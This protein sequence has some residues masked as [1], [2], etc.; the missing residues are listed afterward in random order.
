MLNESKTVANESSA[1]LDFYGDYLEELG[2][3]RRFYSG[4]R[5]FSRDN[6]TVGVPRST[7]K[8]S[9]S[10]K[11]KS[12]S[13]MELNDVGKDICAY[14]SLLII[15]RS[16]STST[17]ALGVVLKDEFGKKDGSQMAE[18]IVRLIRLCSNSEMCE[19][20][21]Q[22][23]DANPHA[24]H[25]SDQ[26]FS[27]GSTKLFDLLLSQLLAF[28]RT[29]GTSAS[30]LKQ[31]FLLLLR[32]EIIRLTGRSISDQV[33][34]DQEDCIPHLLSERKRESR[35]SP[36]IKFV[37]WI[38]R[39]IVL[40]WRSDPPYRDSNAIMM[41]VFQAW[42]FG[43]RSPSTVF[44]SLAARVLSVLVQ[45]VWS[46][47]P[48]PISDFKSLVDYP[49]IYR[50]TL[51]MLS[52][53]R[54]LA[55]TCS[56]YFINIADL[57]MSLTT[58]E[59]ATS[60]LIEESRTHDGVFESSM[61]NRLYSDDSLDFWSGRITQNPTAAFIDMIDSI[62]DPPLLAEGCLVCRSN[63]TSN[64]F[65]NGNFVGKFVASADANV[66]LGRV[67]DY[68]K[69]GESTSDSTRVVR[70]DSGAVE[71]VRWN[72]AD[73]EFDVRHVEVDELG[74]L[75]RIFP[76][77][78]STLDKEKIRILKSNYTHGVI[79]R[80]NPD[81]FTGDTAESSG[82]MEWPE[83]G[84]C[85]LV[86]ICRIGS[87][88]YSITE[89]FFLSGMQCSHGWLSRFASRTWEPGTTYFVSVDQGS[90]DTH[91]INLIG[92]YSLIVKVGSYDVEISGD[93]AFQQSRL[94]WFDARLKSPALSI[95]KDNFVVTN[96][97][98][99]KAVC[100][101]HVGFSSGVH[102]WEF[103]IEQADSGFAFLGVA[104]RPLDLEPSNLNKWFG[105]GMVS[106]RTAFNLLHK[107]SGSIVYGEHFHTGDVVG[108]HLDMN[109]GRLAFFLDGM[110]YGEHLL[111]AMGE[112]FDDL[113]GSDR[114][115]TL[116]LYPIVGLQ[117]IQDRVALTSKWISI[118]GTSC[119]DD[120]TCIY[121]TWTLI[122][123]CYVSSTFARPSNN[124]WLYSQ[125]CR[126]FIAW[127]RGKSRNVRSRA[128]DIQTWLLLDL[129][130]KASAE[131]SI[132][133]GLERALFPG[134]RIKI[135]KSCGR[136]LESSEEAIILGTYR[137]RLWYRLT[138]DNVSEGS[139]LAWCLAPYDSEGLSVLQRGGL[140]PDRL[141]NLELP[142]I[143]Q[144]RGGALKVTCKDGAVMRDGLEI[145]TAD[146]I[147]TIE[148]QTIVFAIEKRLNSSNIV[149]YRV[150]HN[151][152]LGW[153][154]AFMR[155]GT[156]DIMVESIV[157]PNDELFSLKQKM[158]DFF[159]FKG[160]CDKFEWIEAEN[161]VA[162]VK[163]WS[164]SVVNVGCEQLLQEDD[165]HLSIEKFETL[166]HH[167]LG[168]RWTL[169]KDMLLS[170]LISK[171]AT[172]SD[173]LPASDSF[174]NL[175]KAVKS[176]EAE[177]KVFD[178]GVE[179]ILARASLLT[180][181]NRYL[182]W[183]LPFLSLSDPVEQNSSREDNFP[184]CEVRV[185]FCDSLTSEGCFPLAQDQDFAF[186]C[187]TGAQRLLSLRRLM[188]SQTKR[189]FLHAVLH[190]TTTYTPPHVDEYE[191]PREIKLVKVNRVKATPSLLASIPH[192]FCRW[193]QT[194]MGQL[195]SDLRSWGNSNFRRSYVCKGHGG[196]KRCFKVQF[197]GEGVHDY[198][199][200]YRAVFE[201][202]VDELQCDSVLVGRKLSE[203]CLLPLFIPSPNRAAGVGYNQ[204]TFI[205]NPSISSVSVSLMHFLGK[206]LGTAV[207]HNMTLALDVS[208]TFWRALVRLPLTR[209]HLEQVDAL[210]AKSLGEIEDTGVSIEED[211]KAGISY[212]E[213]FIPDEWNDLRFST[214][215]SDGSWVL[216]IPD[217]ESVPVTIKNW[218]RYVHLVEMTRL[219][220]NFCLLKVLIDGIACVLP[221]E[222][223][224]LFT[225][226]EVRL[227]FTGERKLDIE[228]LQAN[229]EYENISPTSDLVGYF[230]DVLHDMDD[231]E[232]TQFLRFV[233]A[234]SRMPA[235]AQD[236]HTKFKLLG[237]LRENPD[238]YLP[239]AQTCFF[240]LTL[241]H[242]SSRDVLKSK[243]LYAIENSP[244]MDADVRLHSAEGWDT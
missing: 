221:R 37:L 53:E 141:A 177:G 213:D 146:V 90:G 108:V 107:S 9:F 60:M 111:I 197:I 120:L 131:S 192:H 45:N 15:I 39:L 32:Y 153:I 212:P 225:A 7:S 40:S 109:R 133:L 18:T 224:P 67:I 79:L 144:F 16:L 100:F 207:R 69:T 101:G 30:N 206:L 28:F 189:I 237:E 227:L 179:S 230:W 145:D 122:S 155:G 102:Y 188:F 84:S 17:T 137:K 46:L 118:P 240:S 48:G 117:R 151:G 214:Y 12:I 139:S 66:E 47:K 50:L 190:A 147:C 140:V 42:Y 29:C 86:S 5:F 216:L 99:G 49:R 194:V 243:L 75:C 198:G 143:P 21:L 205:I 31:A 44:K 127:K 22:P 11:M 3:F 104:E 199:G 24:L 152:A 26:T 97:K 116:T 25:E 126:D 187:N 136:Q 56:E 119:K 172:T 163:F 229:T 83:I 159:H 95:S 203:R 149:R 68:L 202:I 135:T 85:V 112:A 236:F 211:I 228:V 128:N 70:W 217:G 156:E 77:P 234:R 201:Q 182:L 62:H 154:S 34:L 10:K 226:N 232:R 61:R 161:V 219:T 231:D 210:C 57:T 121:R 124:R 89:K 13:N 132:R 223:L 55:P 96:I 23:E 208:N 173:G 191:D 35:G 241:P 33:S 138:G 38:T 160:L 82:V 73:G 103:K 52:E 125:A 134:D 115:R 162:A 148:Y 220:E 215:L 123:D 64:A 158:V 164:S 36:R 200:P 20:D 193:K 78:L 80:T 63:L 186:F 196:Q 181:F 51:S 1:E 105:C 65:D 209:L 98:G 176:L 244:N 72:I 170:E 58:I 171:C 165:V 91:D 242:Y 222:I 4:S 113:H 130:L 233:W 150:L 183:A 178:C 157:L 8:E 93:V 76:L 88:A 19:M 129:S 235:S 195:H 87:S 142:R 14:Y 74:N 218:R 204:D 43:L 167:D 71:I 184:E 6:D 110:K 27:I 238:E 94:F 180:T 168:P 174:L 239:H 185:K 41:H 81:A 59:S 169:E 2:G 106:N 175:E 54:R 92:T 166:A 114:G